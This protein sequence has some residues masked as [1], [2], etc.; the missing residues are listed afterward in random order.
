MTTY[1]RFSQELPRSGIRAIMAI[2]ARTKGL[3]SLAV[4]EPDFRTPPHI[5]EAA[6]EAARAGHTHY[7]PTLGTVALREAVAAR[8]AERWRQP[9]TPDQ[10]LIGAGAVNSIL[11]TLITVVDPGDE[12]LVPD[13][14]WPNYDA[15]IRTARA[16]PVT[17]PLRP[18]A[19]YL[20]DLGELDRLVTSRTRVIITNNP[21]NPSGVVW[22]RERVEALVQ[23]VRKRDLWLLSDEI[24][25]DL[26]FDGEMA[27]AAPYDR[28]RTITISG[29]SKTFAMTGWRLGW[30]VAPQPLIDLALKVQEPLVS[31]AS[32][33]SQQAALAA[34]RGPQEVIEE[35]RAA[36][37]RRR[38]IA[39]ELLG[40]AGMLPTVPAGAFYAMVDV[41]RTGLPSLEVVMR[42]IEEEQ[43]AVVPGTAFGR[44]AE[45]F[46]RISLASSDEHVRTGCER[47]VRFVERNSAAPVR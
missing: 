26:V 6:F 2:A 12:V 37:R 29:C 8:Y 38:D 41:R 9:V 15:Q 46:L 19:G 25:E 22:P 7:T 14:S 5:I 17:Y 24:Y 28:E 43:I 21:C 1:S 40:P 20:P 30:A 33:V 42:L 11:A 44:V 34:L 47:I 16:V 45:G 13:P 39:R 4:G 31:C 23:W 10:V 32:D 35:M 27:W 18:D 3:I 36:Y